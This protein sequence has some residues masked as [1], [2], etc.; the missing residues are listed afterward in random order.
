MARAK[1]DGV[2]FETETSAE[3]KQSSDNANIKETFQDQDGNEN[4]AFGRIKDIFEYTLHEDK[5]QVLECKWFE[6]VGENEK[7][8]LFVYK[9]SNRV[10][11]QIKRFQHLNGMCAENFLMCP[12]DGP[13]LNVNEP[14]PEYNFLAKP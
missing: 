14:R 7:N 4:S 6:Q 5:V 3:G 8:H 1:L 13:D 2:L 11:W 9:E 10:E 12:N